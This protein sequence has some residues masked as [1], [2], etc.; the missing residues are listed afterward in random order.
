MRYDASYRVGVCVV[1]KSACPEFY[2]RTF[3]DGET[4]HTCKK[5]DEKIPFWDK[6]DEC[7]SPEIGA[8]QMEVEDIRK[9]IRAG[10]FQC[11]CL[12]MW[13]LSE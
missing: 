8:I 7:D 4:L 6:C 2:Y 10:T 1:S 11:E 9:Q 13:V 3:P 5:V 12:K